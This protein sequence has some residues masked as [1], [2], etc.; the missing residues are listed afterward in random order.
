MVCL[1]SPSPDL[2]AW[3]H[4]RIAKAHALS[5]DSAA[6]NGTGNTNQP[7]GLL[8]TTGIG[9]V[10]IGTNGGDPTSDIINALE[11]GVA[12]ANGDDATMGFLTNSTMRSRLRKT[13][14]LTSIYSGVPLWVDGKLLDTP[15][16]VSNQIPANLVKGTSS[17]CSAIICGAWDQLLIGEFNGAL[18]IISDPYALAKQGMLEISSFAMY[19]C[20]VL[21][22]AAF[23]VCADARNV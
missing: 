2:D 3:I 7:L 12:L 21:Q 17:D 14:V 23:A 4:T 8:G 19:D 22:P 5:L 1:G 6:I 11:A 16:A 9:S 13:S 15:A 20:V 18:E 10:A